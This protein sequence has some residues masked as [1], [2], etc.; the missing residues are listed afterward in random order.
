[1]ATVVVDESATG[2]QVHPTVA[3]VRSVAL[4]HATGLDHPGLSAVLEVRGRGSEAVAVAVAGQVGQ[5]RLFAMS[6]PSAFINEM[7]RF[8]DNRQ[9]AKSL[10]RYLV[11]GDERTAGRLWILGGSFVQHPGF[12]ES[13]SLRAQLEALSGLLATRAAEVR[14]R[15]LPWWM[16]SLLAVLLLGGLAYRTRRAYLL[17]YRPNVPH[18]AQS[19]ALG[20]QGGLAGRVAVLGAQSTSVSLALVELRL[21]LGEALAEVL[22]EPPDTPLAALVSAW[23]ASTELHA[24]LALRLDDTVRLFGHVERALVTGRALK[25]KAPPLSEVSAVIDEVLDCL[26]H[27]T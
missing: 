5:G 2:K 9:F 14:Q 20:T 17:R 3:S 11:G 16:H 21:L 26:G 8:P 12:A 1:L 4:N 25:V 7:L 6:D 10:G 15:G 19:S 24:S 23:R 22:G 27:G 18:Y 13:N